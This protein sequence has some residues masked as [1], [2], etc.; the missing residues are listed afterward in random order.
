MATKANLDVAERLDITCRKGDTFELS[1]NF[2]DSDGNNIALLTDEYDF[3]MQ[4]RSPKKTANTK[5]ALVAGTL[6]KGD[7]A[8][9]ADNSSNVGFNFEDVDDSGNVTVRASADTMANFVAGRYTY[10]LQY[11][12]NNKTTTVLKGSFTV[13]DD[14]TA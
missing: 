12:V 4:V 11:T 14:I 5:G 6:S 3:F 10:D 8:K 2:K 9:G 1:L 7:Q 13:N